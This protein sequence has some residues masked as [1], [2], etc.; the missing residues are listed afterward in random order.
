[1]VIW[2]VRVV[3]RVG[4]ADVAFRGDERSAMLAALAARNR[5]PNTPSKIRGPRGTCEGCVQGA[6]KGAEA[7]AGG[8]PLR[9]ITTR[10]REQSAHRSTR[11]D[12]SPLSEQ[13][14]TEH[15][16]VAPTRRTAPR[17]GQ[18]TAQPRA[19]TQHP[20]QLQMR[21]RVRFLRHGAAK[22]RRTARSRS[23]RSVRSWTS[24]ATNAASAT[25]LQNKQTKEP[26]GGTYG[27]T[28]TRET[29]IW[30]IS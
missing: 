25:V 6:G 22:A 29:A 11:P 7:A 5:A 19:T 30:R 27:R 23:V 18:R 16:R 15:P 9:R 3:G 14:E 21:M 10:R 4:L 20:Q 2:L 12:S 13:A 8:A 26:P 1:M 28:G 17:R 24:T